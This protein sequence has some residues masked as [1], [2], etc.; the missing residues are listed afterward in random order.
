MF[1]LT[2][3]ARH[4]GLRLDRYLAIEIKE[5]SRVFLQ[6]LIRDGFVKINNEVC[7][8]PRMALKDALEI[9]VEI[10]ETK[11]F[12]LRAEQIAL[13]VLYEDND[14][15]VINKHAGIV[16]H[17]GAGNA[18]G[19]IVN[20]LLGRDAGFAEKFEETDEARPGIVH[21]LDKDTSGCLL[22]AKTPQVLFHMSKAFSAR[23]V[24]KTYAALV[25]GWPQTCHEEIITYMGRH[26]ANRKKM[27]VVTR[28]GKEAIT[29]YELAMKGKIDAVA[30]SLLHVKILTGRTHQIRVHL[31]HKK[32]PVIG[33]EVYGGKQKIEASRQMLHSWKIKFPHPVTGVEMS[34]ESP[35]PEDFK[36][37]LERI[38]D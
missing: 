3:E 15:I 1:K 12:E 38:R 28:N 9:S 17:P 34:F 25:Y 10:P 32:L 30:V 6:N 11:K 22:I 20:A 36:A 18:D 8:L 4:L 27:A 7:T 19:T 13:D 24:K 5:Y 14:I 21:R 35:L 29:E 2:T 16:V 33:D 23:K 26:P 31:A 37:L